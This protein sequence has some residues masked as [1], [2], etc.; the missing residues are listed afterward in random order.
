MRLGAG[1]YH[2]TEVRDEDNE[3]NGEGGA[4]AFRQ[5]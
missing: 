3:D 1:H 5:A 2:D 4:E